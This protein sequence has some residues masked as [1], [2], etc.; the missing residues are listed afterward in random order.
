MHICFYRNTGPTPSYEC[1]YLVLWV[2]DVALV[3][4]LETSGLLSDWVVI[5]GITSCV[6]YAVRD[7]LL[8]AR[9]IT[10]WIIEK[11]PIKHSVRS[12]QRLS[13]SKIQSTNAVSGEAGTVW[14]RSSH[15]WP[16]GAYISTVK[17]KNSIMQKNSTMTPLW[18]M[19]GC[20]DNAG[21]LYT[22]YVSDI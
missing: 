19:R 18:K 15:E 7:L 11:K 20:Q 6:L 4:Y 12:A 14:S 8:L 17:I 13:F 22:S 3:H 21:F 1:V 16:V 10:G 9:Q 5:T 2:A